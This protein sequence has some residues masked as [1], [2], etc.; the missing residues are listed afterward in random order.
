VASIDAK[1]NP[2]TVGMA[3]KMTTPEVQAAYRRRKAIVEPPNA[4]IKQHHRVSPVQQ[5]RLEQS[6]CGMEAGLCGIEFAAHEQTLRRV[7]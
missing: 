3:H 4:W 2:Y 6:T 1:K 5:E 7:K